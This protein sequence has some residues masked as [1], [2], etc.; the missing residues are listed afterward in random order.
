MKH[1]LF[2]ALVCL[3]A[4]CAQEDAYTKRWNDMWYDM[5]FRRHYQHQICLANRAR[6]T[7]DPMPKRIA[8]RERAEPERIMV[9]SNPQAEA[10]SARIAALDQ[11]LQMLEEALKTNAS[12]T[13]ANQEIILGHIRELKQQLQQQEQ[14]R[15]ETTSQQQTIS[16]IIPP[17]K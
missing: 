10:E 4:G 16:A 11:R 13:N 3:C 2:L 12:T 7:R 5:A 8:V 9:R 15:S 17:G 14:Q 6:A 1:I